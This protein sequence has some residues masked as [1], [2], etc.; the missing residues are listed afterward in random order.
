MVLDGDENVGGA[1]RRGEPARKGV[2]IAHFAF[3]LA[4]DRG[5]ALG[6]AGEVRH[7][8][9]DDHKQD[10]IEHFLRRGDLKAI[11]LREIHV[12]GQDHAGDAATSAGTTP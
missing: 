12:A 10:E 1:R 4:G 5:V 9:G 6:L 3:A 8:H 11:E 7:E 2:E